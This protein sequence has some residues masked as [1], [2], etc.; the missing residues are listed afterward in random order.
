MLTLASFLEMLMLICFG[1][2]SRLGP[3]AGAGGVG[4]GA[5]AAVGAGT[6]GGGAGSTDISR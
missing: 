6:G 2:S 5:G 1:V 3:G 4:A